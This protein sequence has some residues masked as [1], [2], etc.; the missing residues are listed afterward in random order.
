[1]DS[2]LYVLYGLVELKKISVFASFIMKKRRYWPKYVPDNMMVD[3]MSVNRSVIIDTLH[4]YIENI[5][6][7]MFCLRKSDYR[8]KIMYTYGEFLF[9]ICQKESTR[10]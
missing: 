4:G 1:M 10:V 5:H 9:P 8:M 7:G 2:L 6:Y 3:H